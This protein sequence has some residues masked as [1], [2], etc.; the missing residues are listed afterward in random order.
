[1]WRLAAEQLRELEQRGERLYP[2]SLGYEEW[3][4]SRDGRDTG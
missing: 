3:L 2:R 4:P 1:M